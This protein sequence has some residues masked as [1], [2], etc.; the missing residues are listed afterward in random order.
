MLNFVLIL[1]A[2]L[3]LGIFIVAFRVGTLSSV[4]ASI[5]K[6]GNEVGSGNSLHGYLFVLLPLAMLVAAGWYG[7]K[8]Y[9]T[10]VLPHASQNA[11]LTEPLFWTATWVIIVMCL[12]TNAALFYFAYK[13]RHKKGNKAEF[14]P[15]NLK[16][17]VVWTIVP[18]VI[19]TV[20]IITGWQAWRKIMYEAPENAKVIEIMGHQFAWKVRYAGADNVLGK[21]D[22]RYVD[23]TNEMGM[24]FTDERT[25]DDFMVNEIHV[26]KG[27]PVELKIRARDVL[28]SVSIPHFRQKMDAVPGMPTRM[29]FVPTKTTAEMRS[30]L[31]EK[32]EW[33]ELDPQSGEP[34]YKNFNYEIACQEICGRGH[35]AMRFVIVVEEESAY[36]EWVAQQKPYVERNAEYVAAAKER[37][38]RIKKEG[39][40]A[41]EKSTNNSIKQTASFQ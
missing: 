37:Q 21:S 36:N 5:N 11:E 28:H 34:R 32:P 27:Q 7:Y 17:E 15:D 9:G 25:N 26:V 35:F 20:L 10:Y 40:V 13:Y 29:W 3:V 18:A 14:Y 2:L 31:S 6:K 4:V 8:Y 12:V 38:M 33:Q 41:M 39:G 24:D 1:A 22:F 30:E 23:D 19:L 16:L